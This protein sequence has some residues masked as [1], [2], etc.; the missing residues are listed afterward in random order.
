MTI[1]GVVSAVRFDATGAANLEL[2][3]GASIALEDVELVTASETAAES[4]VGRYAI[5]WD[6][7]DP[8]AP[9]LVEG[10]V[11][12]TSTDGAGQVT[13]ELDTG[14]SVRLGD[15]IEWRNTAEEEDV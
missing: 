6:R 12:G 9:E 1:S 2:S 8:D 3:N 10:L 4:V 13:L 15:V 11:T 14:Q 5:G 7:S